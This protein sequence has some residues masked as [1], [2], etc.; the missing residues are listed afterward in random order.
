MTEVEVGVE[1]RTVR[2]SNLQ[3][4]MWPG[5]GFT[6]G[7]MISY[8][9]DVATALLPH[10]R[11]RPLTLKRYPEGV[12]GPFW[13]Q[14]Q[15]PGRPEW[16]ATRPVPSV[17]VEGKILDYCV[18]N[19]LP[20]LVWIVNLGTIELHPLLAVEH[21]VHQPTAVVIDLDPG[22][23]AGLLDACQVGLRVRDVLTDLGLASFAKTSGKGL[24]VYVP[25]N[26]SVT[27]DETKAFARALARL[28]TQE[29]PDRVVDRMDRSLRRNKVFIDWSQND[30]TKT[31][32]N[33][34]SLR[35]KER[36]IASTPVTWAEVESALDVRDADLLTFEARDVV[37]R[38]RK[39]GDLFAPVLDLRQTLPSTIRR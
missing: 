25:L 4:V 22:P 27:Y 31:T 33:V 28:L 10:L 15:C 38:V 29:Q 32:V 12:E 1:G 35:A 16:M 13:F 34:Y 39:G 8:Y 37:A 26:T 24:H 7:E 3:R 18:V 5:T 17:T 11:Q 36:P 30:P 21:D 14:K 23:P 20:G 9:V 19:D 2:L 6:K